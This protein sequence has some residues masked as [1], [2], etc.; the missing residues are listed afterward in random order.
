M[1]KFKA[2]V[3]VVKGFFKG[4]KGVVIKRHSSQESDRYT[5]RLE[6]AGAQSTYDEVFKVEEIRKRLI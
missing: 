3:K 5:V 1:F 2:K 6:I 4:A